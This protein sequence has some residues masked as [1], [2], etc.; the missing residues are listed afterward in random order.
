MKAERLLKDEKGKLIGTTAVDQLTGDKYK[1]KAKVIINA[2]GVFVDEIMKMDAP[3]AKKKVRPSQ[4][5]HLVV[6]SK[7]L[8]GNSALMIPKTKDGRVLFGVP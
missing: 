3:E 5:V 7:F 2:T 6:D 4:G 8:G 1:I